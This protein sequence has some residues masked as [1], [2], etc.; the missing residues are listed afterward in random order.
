MQLMI[1]EAFF[2]KIDGRKRYGIDNDFC[3]LSEQAHALSIGPIIYRCKLNEYNFAE[4]NKTWLNRINLFY[5][6]HVCMTTKGKCVMK[7][8]Y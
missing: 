3:V 5:D 4:Q 2:N 6:K 7:N 8:S 1:N